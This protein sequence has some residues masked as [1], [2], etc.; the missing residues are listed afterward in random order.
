MKH[1]LS[2][3]ETWVEVEDDG[4]FYGANLIV[5]TRRTVNTDN[6]EL[7]YSKDYDYE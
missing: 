6:I 1:E 3:I 2:Q 4:D 5:E 7:N